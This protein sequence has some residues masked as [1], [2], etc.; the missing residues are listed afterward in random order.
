MS[1]PNPQFG[2]ILIIPEQIQDKPEDDTGA[3]NDVCIDT[4]GGIIYVKLAGTWTQV[5]PI[6]IL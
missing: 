2:R 1:V 5:Y 6:L 3:D 4:L